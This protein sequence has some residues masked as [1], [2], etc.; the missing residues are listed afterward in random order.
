MFGTLAAFLIFGLLWASKGDKDKEY[1]TCLNLCVRTRACNSLQEIVPP[2]SLRLFGWTCYSDCQYDC[3]W[4]TVI[5]RRSRGL[6]IFQYHGKW[7]FIRVLGFQEIASV[8]LSFANGLAHWVGYRK[9]SRHMGKKTFKWFLHKH[10]VFY[11][12]LSLIT[13]ASAM[14]FH[15][16]DVWWTER[17][18]YLTAIISVFFSLYMTILRHWNLV[19]RKHQLLVAIP[20]FLLLSYH[21]HY[22][23]FVLFDYGWNMTLLAIVF[24]TVSLIW[25]VWGV[26][27]LRTHF[28]AKLALLWTFG[29]VATCSLALFHFYPIWDLVDAHALWHAST[30]PLVLLLWK[31]YRLDAFDY[32]TRPILP[33]TISSSHILYSK[34]WVL[35][36]CTIFIKY[37]INDAKFPLIWQT[38]HALC[39]YFSDLNRPIFS[40]RNFEQTHLMGSVMD[41]Q[42]ES[43]CKG[44]FGTHPRL[45]TNLGWHPMQLTW[46]LLLVQSFL[47]VEAQELGTIHMRLEGMREKCLVEELPENT[48]AL[49]TFNHLVNLGNIWIFFLLVKHS[50]RLWDTLRNAP[51]PD[52]NFQ[53]LI[54]VRVQNI[55]I[56]AMVCLAWFLG[57]EGTHCDQTAKSAR[58]TCFPYCSNDWWAFDLFP[59]STYPVPT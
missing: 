47:Y 45:N 14:L 7:P 34:D 21:L 56:K 4:K 25:F 20:I 26:K 30:V 8:I 11:R 13:W 9:Y 49:G 41:W 50:A 23:C 15:T 3:M 51:M 37:C 27:H 5:S 54:T 17:A 2:L 18:D 33:E 31:I 52:Q 12:N 43:K 35:V 36:Y 44:K 28:Y 38:W 1:Q 19:E 48:V 57:S 39:T 42:F 53:L 55:A 10:Y 40:S 59:V 32:V 6:E 24:A 58:W 46:L 22:M 16:R 29:A